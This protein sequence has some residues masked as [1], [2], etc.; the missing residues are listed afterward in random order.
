M[1]CK[2]KQ[3]T[4]RLDNRQK[5]AKVEETEAGVEG[6]EGAGA[7][8]VDWVANAV[9]QRGRQKEGVE[10][11]A[12]E[13]AAKERVFFSKKALC[14][15]FHWKNLVARC[16]TAHPTHNPRRSP[17]RDTYLDNLNRRCIDCIARPADLR[18]L[19]RIWMQ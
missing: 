18:L 13:A 1:F 15:P 19:L 5:G 9:A 11:G 14:L 8:T 3:R 4:L 16:Q 7:T 2:S 10:E 17:S 6:G 12:G